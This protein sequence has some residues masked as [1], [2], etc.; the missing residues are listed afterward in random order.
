MT[1]GLIIEEGL[2]WEV[3]DAVLDGVAAAA[4]EANVQVVAGDTKV[5][6]RGAADRLF[7]NSCGVGACVG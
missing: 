5:V 7:L 4:R 3:L 2:E 6:P 1:L